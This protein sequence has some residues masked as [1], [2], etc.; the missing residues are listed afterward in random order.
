MIKAHYY[1][2]SLRLLPLLACLLTAAPVAANEFRCFGDDQTWCAWTV[3]ESHPEKG[4]GATSKIRLRSL[5]VETVIDAQNDVAAFRVHVSPITPAETVR[6]AISIREASQ[7][8]R[9][10]QNFVAKEQV[11]DGAFVRFKLDRVA[12]EAVIEAQP[13]AYLYVFIE[14]VNGANNHKVSHKIGLSKLD[15]ALR[16]ARSGRR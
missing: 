7:G 13:S 3:P 6:V 16:F 15:A 12:L 1:T 8:W 10:W 2:N 4:W 5:V 14:V 11:I 9:R